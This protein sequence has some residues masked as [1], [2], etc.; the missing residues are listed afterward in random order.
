MKII[1]IIVVDYPFSRSTSLINL[2]R[3]LAKNYDLKIFCESVDLS[4]FPDELKKYIISK[5]QFKVSSTEIN[6]RTNNS[7]KK[8]LTLLFL[9]SITIYL[10]NVFHNIRYLLKLINFGKW[11]KSEKLQG[12]I[13]TIDKWGLF[14]CLVAGYKTDI[15]YS[16]EACPLFECKNLNIFLFTL[17]E[18]IY[19][20]LAHPALI[21]QSNNRIALIDKYFALK[22]FIL[23]ATS[24]GPTIVKSDFLRLHL[25]IPNYKKIVL[26]AGGLGQDQLTEEIVKTVLFWDDNFILVLHFA[27]GK[28]SKIV[29]EIIA[30]NNLKDKV[31]ISNLKLTLDQAQNQVFS[32]ADIGIVYYRNINSN[33]R[34]V[35]YSSGK[36]SDN[37]R[38]GVPV[39]VP[40]FGDFKSVIDKYDF[41]ITSSLENI[42]LN[43]LTINKNLPYYSQNAYDAYN[44]VYK[45]NNYI[46]GLNKFIYDSLGK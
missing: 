4:D 7:L 9:Y 3:E 13:I 35:A 28:P 17:I 30:R 29:K 33:Y 20:K 22:S 2:T 23:P 21:S 15:Y 11:L 6:S 40:D 34:N 44:E 43:L 32:G 45:F 24:N 19:L 12:K 38:C 36:L 18:K 16:L 39:I 41:G 46:S 14:P 42:P 37:L 10:I 1:N 25:K 31:V 26:M 8:I 5:N 27:D